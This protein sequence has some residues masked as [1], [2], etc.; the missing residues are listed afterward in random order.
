MSKKNHTRRHQAD[1]LDY[2][3]QDREIR[4]DVPM[5]ALALRPG[6]VEIDSINSVED[7]KGNNGQHG[8]LTVTNLRLIWVAHRTAAASNKANLTIGFSCIMNTAIKTAPSEIRGNTQGLYVMTKHGK[9]RYEFIFT[10]LVKSSPRLF[11]TTQAV[12]ES[13][14]ST[15]LYRDL[16][17]RGAIIKDKQLLVL[18]GESIYNKVEGVMNLSSDQGNLGTF[19]ITN[20][21]LVWHA[22]LA[23]NFNVS[24]PYI[25]IK[26]AKVRDSK[27]GWALVIDT[28]PKSGGYVLG[29]RIDPKSKLEEVFKEISTLNTVYSKNPS[30]G[31]KFTIEDKPRSLADQK[32]EM[33]EDDIEIEDGGQQYSLSSYY[34]DD[35]DGASAV[36]VYDS[37]LGLAVQKL[38]DKM[39]GKIESLWEVIEK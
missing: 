10:S 3:W 22:N 30:F 16:K 9:A 6:E 1:T 39:N 29:F 28:S 32:V 4:F 19:F 11:T 8:Q 15:K 17:L 26:G 14:E 38:P 34:A 5:S 20:I 21:R 27:F 36:P 13:Y 7:T 12:R 31:V 18:P 25:Q 37:S 24:I 35:G 23:E 2:L 33:V